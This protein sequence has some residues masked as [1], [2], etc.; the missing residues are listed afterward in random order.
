M[1]KSA[2][3]FCIQL[4]GRHRKNMLRSAPC[5]WW[6]KWSLIKINKCLVSLP[7]FLQCTKFEG[8]TSCTSLNFSIIFQNTN[9]GLSPIPVRQVGKILKMFLGGFPWSLVNAIERTA[10]GHC[11]KCIWPAAKNFVS[12][13]HTLPASLHKFNEASSTTFLQGGSPTRQRFPGS[14]PSYLSSLL[15]ESAHCTSSP[16]TAWSP[17]PSPLSSSFSSLPNFPLPQTWC[18]DGSGPQRTS[19]AG[20]A[21]ELRQAP[22]GIAPSEAPPRLSSTPG[23]PPGSASPSPSPS[24]R[25]RR[26]STHPS[27]LESRYISAAEKPKER[28]TKSFFFR[29]CSTSLGARWTCR[30]GTSRS[31]QQSTQSWRRWENPF[32]AWTFSR[33][34][35][36]HPTDA[37]LDLS[38]G[39]ARL[40]AESNVRGKRRPSPL[41][42]TPRRRSQ[43]S[44][45]RWTCSGSRSRVGGGHR[46]LPGILWSSDRGHGKENQ[47]LRHPK[48]THFSVAKSRLCIL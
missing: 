4:I 7:F 48:Q 36:Y 8:E 5:N 40:H 35:K 16:C 29:K 19:G 21:W 25:R 37:G 26:S 1:P 28:E 27:L 3:T 17:P 9:L 39:R 46:Q 18:L 47:C 20:Q 45:L 33:Q 6:S 41:W 44:P 22:A 30:G 38:N 31:G 43:P 11:S 24:W 14:A 12:A 32:L 13:K 42:R 23:W 34:C 2:L 10:C 15:A